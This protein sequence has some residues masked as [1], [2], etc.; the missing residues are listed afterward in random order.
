MPF[1]SGVNLGFSRSWITLIALFGILLISIVEAPSPS[2]AVS[3]TQ[4]PIGSGS[5]N[6]RVSCSSPW[7]VRITD[8]TDNMTGSASLSNS[9][10]NPGITSP[11][12]TAKR[13]LTSGATPPGWVSPGPPCTIT[14]SH[15]QV[16]M[17]VEI[18]GVKRGSISNEDCTGTYDPVNGGASN[19]GNYCDTTFN[20]YD[21]AVVPT[22]SSSCSNSSD[23]TCYG[24]IHIE[25]DHDWKAAK[26][27]GASTA[28]DDVAINSQTTSSSV[29]DVQ[30]FV[31]WDP[32][33]LNQQWHS[34]SGWEIHP[35]T[36]WRFHQSTPPSPDFSI[37]ASPASISV[38]PGSSGT[39][40]IS[41]ASIGGFTG[42]VSLSSTVSPSGPTV[43]LNPASI[44][45]SSGSTAT[46][47][48]TVQTQ[49][50]TPIGTYTV[51]VKGS[52]GSL[53]HSTT[54]SV[55]VGVSPDF[56]ISA[57]PSSLTV[58]QSSSTTSTITLTSMNGFS[59][60][61]SLST[62]IS[63]SGP[64]TS[65]SSSTLTLTSGGSAT[66]ILSIRALHKTNLGTYTITVTA[67]S[68]SVSHSTTINLTV[69]A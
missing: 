58:S 61:V 31:Y 46:S 51:T 19:G 26:Y 9:I 45:L 47:T 50:S 54:V 39:S 42:T 69:T 7:I 18:D 68:G 48:L 67:T 16:S 49:S 15:G 28:C 55:S 43:S 23:K 32:G 21:P 59:G 40:S 20:I 3:S 10:F 53:S 63:P 4:Y 52:S 30:G 37:S 8:I 5:W 13:W 12:G 17:F 57:N 29:L 11:V 35:V 14:N 62:S 44:T 27:C 38:P 22:Y 33:N 65:L 36:G 64:K 60:A 41:L 1:D 24:R 6:P 2:G 34:F 56:S 66:S 25:I